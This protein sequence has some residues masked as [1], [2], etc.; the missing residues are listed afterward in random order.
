MR[1]EYWTCRACMGRN[2]TEDGPVCQDCGLDN[3]HVPEPRPVPPKDWVAP[4]TSEDFL[5]GVTVPE[6][7]DDIPF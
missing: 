2:Y 5:R 6:G 3:S 4:V 1:P 7:E